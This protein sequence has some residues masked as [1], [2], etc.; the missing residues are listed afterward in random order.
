MV[1][2]ATIGQVQATDDHEE[3]DLKGEYTAIRCVDRQ[4]VVLAVGQSGKWVTDLEDPPGD[5][6]SMFIYT[7]TK[8]EYSTPEGDVADEDIVYAEPG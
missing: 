4:V 1:R 7:Y 8:P 3:N 5:Y 6:N 2:A